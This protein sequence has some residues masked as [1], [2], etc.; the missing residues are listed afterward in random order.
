MDPAIAIC[1]IVLFGLLFL[2]VPI[3]VSLGIAVIAA[4]WIGEL[5]PMLFVQKLYA[6][7]ES[8]PTMAIPF[9]LMSGAIMQRGSM[10]PA[11]IKVSRT[12]V[13][14]IP[15]GLVHV[16]ILTCIFYGALCGSA[17]ATLAAVGGILIPAM[18]KEGYP[19]GFASA[20]NA[21]GGTLGVLIPPSIT[22]IMYGSTGGVSISDLFI[23]S[24]L[25]GILAGLSIMVVGGY[26]A[27]KN[28]YGK[29]TPRATARERMEALWEAKWALMVPVIV[30]G[31]LYGGIVTP[32]EAG[33]V[34]VVYSLIAESFITKQLTLKRLC[35]VVVDTVRNTAVIFFLIAS[36]QCLGM[37]LMQY[38]CHELF[39]NW[40]TGITHNPY[41]FL[42][43]MMVFF[44]ILGCILEGG[45]VILV[46]TPFIMPVLNTLGIDPIHFG[47]LFIFALIIG[48][49]T[50]PVGLNLFMGAT[51]GDVSFAVICRSV[52]PYVLA[53]V[54]VLFLLV[55]I[56]QLSTC[57]V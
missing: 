5:E 18:K 56:P 19:A 1:F 22:L 24:T 9:F 36:S 37:V 32:T 43:A 11:L 16:S 47:V 38:N 34:A 48:N 21:T 17:V 23:A 2:T 54:A 39:A 45:S 28:G 50:P 44:L 29:Q 3:A 42:C 7:F 52:V 10:A 14:H 25:P 31:G 35:E 46:L 49:L 41:V 8:Y 20:I 53:M 13:G 12:L 55:F 6:S 51:I 15:G 27:W 26:I 30:L 57:F 33:M 4:L 40:V